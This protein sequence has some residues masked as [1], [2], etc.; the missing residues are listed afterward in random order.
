MVICPHIVSFRPNATS[1]CG[2]I[3][4][5]E[6]DYNFEHTWMTVDNVCHVRDYICDANGPSD[7]DRIGTKIKEY[8]RSPDNVRTAESPLETNNTKQTINRR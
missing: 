5:H 7:N 3:V 2:P 4:S 1:S 6:A 8:K